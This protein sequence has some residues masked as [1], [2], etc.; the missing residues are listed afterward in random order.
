[1]ILAAV[2]KTVWSSGYA[3]FSEMRGQ[4]FKSRNGQIKRGFVNGSLPLQHFEESRVA[5]AMT[6]G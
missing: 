3:F 1:M 2:G 5:R 4:R 6:W